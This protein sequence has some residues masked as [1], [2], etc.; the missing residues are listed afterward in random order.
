[1]HYLLRLI[2]IVGIE[3]DSI[4]PVSDPASLSG[5]GVTLRIINHRVS[6]DIR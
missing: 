4:C 2:E 5:V 6:P 3:N 1:L